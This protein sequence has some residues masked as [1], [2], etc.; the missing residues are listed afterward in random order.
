MKN[1]KKYILIVSIVLIIISTVYFFVGEFGGNPI[2]VRLNFTL[3]KKEYYEIAEK[4]LMQDKI[5]NIAFNVNSEIINN[6]GDN[7][8]YHINEE[9][10]CTEGDYPNYTNVKLKN[11]DAVLSYLKISK[12]EYSYYADFLKK[13]HL[14]GIGKDKDK[15]LVEIEDKLEGLRYY[16]QDNSEDFVIDNEY[17]S[18]KKI[19]NHWFSYN[20]DWN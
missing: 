6:C 9:W 10:S 18:V 8:E 4:F 11:K 20:R 15:R 13:Y 16:Q 1:K 14:T 17:L 5:K 7:P 19:D 12:E 3:H 2:R